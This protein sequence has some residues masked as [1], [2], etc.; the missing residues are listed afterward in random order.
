MA[1]LPEL[2]TEFLAASHELERARTEQRL[3]ARR[4][5]IAGLLKVLDETREITALHLSAEY[6]YDDEGGYFRYLSGS[7][8]LTADA[9]EDDGD[10]W[11]EGL[12]VEQAVVLELF[13]LDDVGEAELTREQLHEFAKQE[14]ISLPHSERVCHDL[15]EGAPEGRR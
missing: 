12:D 14:G 11:T 7:L 15:S 2:R 10:Y 13:G 1:S 5:L 9:C 4:Y 3:V 6:E 8:T